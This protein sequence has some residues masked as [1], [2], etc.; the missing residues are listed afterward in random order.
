MKIVTGCLYHE[1]NTFN[2]FPTTVDDFV[3]VEG[4]EVEERLAS[5]EV[6]E[7]NG[8]EIIPS[9]YATALSSG[10]VKKRSIPA[11]C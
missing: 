2:P 3:L 4:K 8:V 6:F 10:I 7:K 9:I 5:T 11:L 1:T